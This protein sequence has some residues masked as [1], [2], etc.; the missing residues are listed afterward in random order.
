MDG[1]NLVITRAFDLLLAPV[2]A[3]PAVALACVSIVAG[4]IMAIVYRATSNQAALR[5]AADRSWAFIQ[6]MRLFRDDLRVALRY[7]VELVAA[8]ARRL[9]HALPPVLVLV[10]PF[11]LVMTQLAIRYERRPLRV[12]ESAVVELRA[13]DSGWSDWRDA[14]L[15]VPPGVVVETPGLRDD[16]A[17][18]VAWRVRLTDVPDGP[19]RFRSPGGAPVETSLA[20]GP[21]P[22]RLR[23]VSWRRVDGG[24]IDRALHPAE[25]AIDR[26]TAVR[27]IAIQYPRRATPILG[28]DVAWWVTFIVLSIVAAL[29]ARPFL[30]M[31]F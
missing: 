30:R 16:H 18:T 27:E 8:V 22:T 13:A 17:R 15:D 14:R 5:E 4:V 28:L 26:T 1:F 7:Q 20:G 25:A 2:A 11:V 24:W 6:G 21:E 23:P 3:W 29:L 31:Q 12:G 9:W 10:L 19:L